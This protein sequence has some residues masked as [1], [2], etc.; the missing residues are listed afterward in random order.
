MVGGRERVRPSRLEVMGRVERSSFSRDWA[1]SRAVDL[2]RSFRL[3][4][5]EV[6]ERGFGSVARRWPRSKVYGVGFETVTGWLSGF[7]MAGIEVF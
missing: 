3:V 7:D 5:S 1:P 4:M 2:R 6:D